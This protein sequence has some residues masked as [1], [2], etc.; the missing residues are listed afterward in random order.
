MR[1]FLSLWLVISF[2]GILVPSQIV[3][4]QENAPASVDVFASDTI[5]AG[6]D[7]PEDRDIRNRITDIFAEFVS[8]RSVVVSVKSGVVTL[9]GNV[10]DPLAIEQAETLAA[11]VEGVVAVSNQLLED[12]SV[13]ERIVPM[14]ERLTGRLIQALHYIPLLTVALLAFLVIAVS[15]WW[16]AARR[17]PFERIAPNAFI[18]DLLRQ[19]VRMVFIG[20]G[21]VLALD[22]IGATAVIGTVL[23]A[24]GIVG[25]AVG[26]AVRDTVENYI[27]SILLSLRQ[28]FRPNDFVEISGQLGRVIMLTSRATVL[29]S[30]DGNHIRIPNSTVFKSVITN[31]SRHPE[32]RFGFEMGIAPAGDLQKAVETGLKVLDE[33][34]FVLKKPSPEARIEKLG[35]STI[36]LWF[37]GWIDQRET[38]L[39]LARAQAIQRIMRALESEGFEL[40]EPGYRI[41]MVGNE[42]SNEKPKSAKPKIVEPDPLQDADTAVVDD[43][44]QI[45]EEERANLHGQDL[46]KEDA[47]QE[48][49]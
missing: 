35:D 42:T 15:G 23:G 8:L 4:A 21:F 16:L 44:T 37:A 32:R 12:T 30:V 33:L 10:P 14:M 2:L 26:F 3:H 25:L 24:A 6:N 19:I 22:I 1:H 41:T 18:S 29:L 20:L 5:S 36:Q 45:V 27:A 28:P 11:R 48:I 31:Y 43:I 13:T 9:S 49:S 46:L 38:S 17:W 34:D 47:P 39:L 7:V 40:P